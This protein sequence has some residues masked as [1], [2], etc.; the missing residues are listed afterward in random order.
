METTNNG[1]FNYNPSDEEKERLGINKAVQE[2]RHREYNTVQPDVLQTYPQSTAN[3]P[4]SRGSG[5]L[6]DPMIVRIS[7]QQEVIQDMNLPSAPPQIQLQAPSQI[8]QQYMMASPVEITAQAEQEVQDQVYFQEDARFYTT[9]AVVD[10]RSGKGRQKSYR[11]LEVETKIKQ[12]AVCIA[13]FLISSVQEVTTEEFEEDMVSYEVSCKYFSNQEG[14][15]KT[16]VVSVPEEVLYSSKLIGL[17]RWEFGSTH[18]PFPSKMD[19]H[20]SNY[21]SDYILQKCQQNPQKKE[22]WKQPVTEDISEFSDA[23]K[24]LLSQMFFQEIYRHASAEAKILLSAG[25]GA[26]CMDE[27]EELDLIS[28]TPRMAKLIIVYGCQSSEKHRYITALTSVL[29]GQRIKKLSEVKV[30]AQKDELTKLFFD[31]QYQVLFFDD[32]QISNYVA[33][34]NIGKIHHIAEYVSSGIPM[35][36]TWTVPCT[37]VVF[38]KRK[39]KEFNAFAN[40]CIF[41][42]GRKIVYT[43]AYTP[44]N[45]CTMVT[46]FLSL[47][48]SNVDHF[49][50]GGAEK[51]KNRLHNRPGVENAV[52]NITDLYGIY[53]Y[54]CKS[55]FSIYGINTSESVEE[56]YLNK[57]KRNGSGIFNDLSAGSYLLSDHALVS[58]FVSDFNRMIR[59]K[60]IMVEPYDKSKT[61]FSRETFDITGSRALLYVHMDEEVLLFS[62]DDFEKL[63]SSPVV[64][65]KKLR[66]ILCEHNCMI[67]NYSEKSC[68]R[69]PV[70]E[71]KLYAAV[72]VSCLGE[73]LRAE[74]P[75]L[76]PVVIPDLKDGT[77]RILLGSDEH[78]HPVYWSLSKQENR[79]V[80]IQG[81]T[82]KGKTYFTTTRLIMG[83]HHAGCNIIIFESNTPSYSKDE[84]FEKCRLDK[85][86]ISDNFYHGRTEKAIEIIKEFEEHKDKVYVVSHKI[87]D[88]EKWELCGLIFSYQRDIFTTNRASACPLFVVFEEA[89]NGPPLHDIPEVKKIYNEGSKMRLSVITILQRFMGKGSQNFRDMANQASLKVS[90]RCGKNH[91]R[92]FTDSIP[93]EK[94]REKMKNKLP[95]LET[96]EAVVCGDFENQEGKL[97]A[98]CFLIKPSEEE[99]AQLNS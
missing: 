17:F 78:G 14:I 30:T 32:D 48:Y 1:L 83:L 81:D 75:E 6:N 85:Q 53:E 27:L 23:D 3:Q 22:V 80:L 16:V 5:T 51:I 68:F 69:M 46:R 15:E 38:T 94:I 66:E 79:S 95:L 96:G 58:Q 29:Y 26:V 76:H 61:V 93:I 98:G 10:K 44:E 77:K 72:K 25:F 7:Q 12:T 34:Q 28:G 86:Y 82:R 57:N 4:N 74:L 39:L 92:Y 40:D 13:C 62:N 33:K 8:P 9:F 42:D 41:L 59:N 88:E 70:D 37:A 91:V 56:Q 63:F 21:L 84:L 2:M 71:R 18:L 64:E 47:L 31:C 36:E 87:S 55:M 99:L 49:F 45:I 50:K 67:I 19:K 43:G 73:E 54:I 35:E 60:L 24:K 52:Q 89:G 20:C 90:F 65:T 97:E 11:P